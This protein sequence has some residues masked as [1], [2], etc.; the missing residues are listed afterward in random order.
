MHVPATALT[1]G[2]DAI[3]LCRHG[4]VIKQKRAAEEDIRKAREVSFSVRG[5]PFESV[6]KFLYLGHQLLSIDDN[7]PDV[8]NNLAKAQRPWATIYRV[9]IRDGATPRISAM[10]YNAVVQLVL[11]YGSET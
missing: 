1:G 3:L 4:H 7:W 9:L 10:F 8:V 6:S 11:L 2:H 5:V